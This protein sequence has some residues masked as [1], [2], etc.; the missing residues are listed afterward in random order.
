MHTTNATQMQQTA[1]PIKMN[2]KRVPI[3]SDEVTDEETDKLVVEEDEG[4]ELK[5]DE[6][7]ARPVLD[8]TAVPEATRVRVVDTERELGLAVESVVLSVADAVLPAT[9]SPPHPEQVISRPPA[10][11]ESLAVRSTTINV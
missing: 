7:L 2:I 6:L 10:H 8:K 5:D 11:T 3:T 1:A 9:Q 4:D